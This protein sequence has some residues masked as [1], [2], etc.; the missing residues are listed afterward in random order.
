MVPKSPAF[1]SKSVAR[2]RRFVGFN[3][4]R[5]RCLSESHL[6]RG[7]SESI[8]CMERDCAHP[9]N[10]HLL[11]HLSTTAEVDNSNSQDAN[12][13]IPLVTDLTM[14]SATTGN[15]KRSFVLLKVMLCM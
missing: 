6:P 5:Y 2:R 15:S 1:L 11:L 10:H 12:P 9:L 13:S 14:N 8:S 3:K 7:C 4:L